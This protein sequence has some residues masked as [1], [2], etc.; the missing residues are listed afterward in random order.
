[1]G[2]AW[3]L[4]IFGQQAWMAAAASGSLD[5]ASLMANLILCRTACARACAADKGQIPLAI[6]FAADSLV[7][8]DG[9]EPSVPLPGSYDVA[10]GCPLRPHRMPVTSPPNVRH[11]ATSRG[12]LVLI[13]RITN[14]IEVGIS[15]F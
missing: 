8:G 4:P 7:E 9:F 12:P 14:G 15:D 6:R 10:T 5:A 11:A 13:A 3:P 2:P 1:M